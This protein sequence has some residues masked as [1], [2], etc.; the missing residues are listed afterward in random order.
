MTQC[1]CVV[2]CCYCC[3]GG[4]AQV[5]EIER[6]NGMWSTD[7][8]FCKTSIKIPVSFNSSSDVSMTNSLDRSPDHTSTTVVARI[9]RS[10][11][12][13]P[14]QSADHR[15]SNDCENSGEEIRSKLDTKRQRKRNSLSVTAEC[16]ED[17]VKSIMDVL[18]CADIQLRISQEF[19]EK[20]AKKRYLFA[21]S[22]I[23][24]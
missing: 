18:E 5:H 2:F 1:D 24:P 6:V 14:S 12:T 19:V 7:S 4:D 20:L 9:C 8:M 11:D 22:I 23:H 17:G 15:G 16:G 10:V 13:C 21:R 3:G